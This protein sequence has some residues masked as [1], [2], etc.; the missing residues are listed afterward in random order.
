MILNLEALSLLIPDLLGKR[1]LFLVVF[2]F[3]L[4]YLSAVIT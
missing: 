3:G 1:I 4:A 2:V